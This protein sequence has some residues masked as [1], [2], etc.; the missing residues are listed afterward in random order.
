M[1]QNA[2][3]IFFPQKYTT[4][5][6]FYNFL[7]NIGS[8]SF[9]SSDMHQSHHLSGC[10]ATGINSSLNTF[11][12]SF[13]FLNSRC[14]V[15]NLIRIIL[16]GSSSS[17]LSARLILLRSIV[18]I[19]IPLQSNYSFTRIFIKIEYV[20]LCIQNSKKFLNHFTSN[21]PIRNKFQYF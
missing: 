5:T 4:N 20:V 12:S 19:P 7:M 8:I 1:Y 10:R 16:S 11:L 2:Y 6:H 14:Q 13:R 21:K 9:S 15:K 3:I 18:R 17:Y